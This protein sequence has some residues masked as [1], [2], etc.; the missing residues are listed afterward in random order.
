MAIR[1]NHKL[2]GHLQTDIAFEIRNIVA[3]LSAFCTASELLI[4]I[5]LLSLWDLFKFCLRVSVGLSEFELA[6]ALLSMLGSSATVPIPLWFVCTDMKTKRG[7]TEDSLLLLERDRVGM[8]KYT[9]DI[10][11]TTGYSVH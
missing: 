6:V 2:L 10:S 3:S 7:E 4:L 1:G 8:W 9:T 5:L 11:C